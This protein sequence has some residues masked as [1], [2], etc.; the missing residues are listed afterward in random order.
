MGVFATTGPVSRALCRSSSHRPVWVLRE[1]AVEM[2][3]GDR[4]SVAC[5]GAHGIDWRDAL[6]CRGPQARAGAGGSVG[7]I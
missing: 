5:G 7:W 6:V 3:P 1:D 4:T 2:V